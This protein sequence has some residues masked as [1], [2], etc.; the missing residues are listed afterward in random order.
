HRWQVLFFVSQWCGRPESGHEARMADQGTSDRTES[1]LW[2]RSWFAVSFYG[3]VT[4]AILL[5]INLPGA[6][7]YVGADN[8]DVM[9]LVQVRDLLAGQSWL[10]LTQYRLALDGG[11]LMHWSR[12]VD[13]P[14]AGLIWAFAQLLPAERA[15]AAAL[16]VWP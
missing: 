11:T 4:V 13:L 2:S 7:D 16:L 5:L 15:E 6:T 10:D 12:L 1:W 3:V 14:I 8:D 9:R